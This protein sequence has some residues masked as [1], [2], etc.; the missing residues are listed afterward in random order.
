[1]KHDTLCFGGIVINSEPPIHGVVMEWQTQQTCRDGLKKDVVTDD[2]KDEG[3]ILSH[4][5]KN[6]LSQDVWVRVP[7]SPPVR[8]TPSRKQWRKTKVFEKSSI[9]GIPLLDFRKSI[10]AQASQLGFCKNSFL[11]ECSQVVWH[12]TFNRGSG[13]FNS[14]HSHQSGDMSDKRPVDRNQHTSVPTAA[15]FL[16]QE[17]SS[18]GRVGNYLNR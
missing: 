3:S 1:M 13:E 7:S 4:D 11:W 8:H 18:V 12:A 15:L 14:P 16:M 10:A 5:T 9:G 17:G 2:G 6:L